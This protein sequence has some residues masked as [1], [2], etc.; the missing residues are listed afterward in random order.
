[1]GGKAGTFI[2]GASGGG[3]LPD[4]PLQ[5]RPE[6]TIA[7]VVFALA[8]ETYAVEIGKVRE[9]IRVP[10]ITWVTGAPDFVRGVVNLRGSVVAV[11]DIAHI[12]FS[13]PIS[14][15]PEARIIIVESGGVTVGMLVEG[16]TRVADIE[17]SHLEPALRTLDESQRLCVVA[18]SSVDNELIGILDLEKV[19]E[20]ARVVIS[21]REGT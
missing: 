8:G 12:L 17:P 6:G 21:P 7:F 19:M 3:N 9:I 15:S 1:M 13:S 2:G 11:L 20:R 10:R 5:D 14:E 18:Q 16:V 4:S